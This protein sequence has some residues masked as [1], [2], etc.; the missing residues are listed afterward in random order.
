MILTLSDNISTEEV[1]RR[2]EGIEE[3]IEKNKFNINF[4][5]ISDLRILE[6]NKS[7]D[8]DQVFMIENTIIDPVMR[9]KNLSVVKIKNIKFNQYVSTEIKR[10]DGDADDQ[11]VEQEPEEGG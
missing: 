9:I 5:P 10:L 4:N 1:N 8:N 7:V 2:I 3:L 6:L 11:E